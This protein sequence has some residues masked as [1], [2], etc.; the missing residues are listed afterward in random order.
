MENNFT[1]PNI[2]FNSFKDFKVRISQIPPLDV[3]FNTMALSEYE[4]LV[5]TIYRLNELI[6]YTNSYT[7]LINEI[8]IWV[9]NDGLEMAVLE[10]L[11]EWKE[12][13][14]LETIINDTLFNSK[15]DKDDFNE[16][17]SD[18]YE[19]FIDG[20]DT[21]ITDLENDLNDNLELKAD[22]TT[23]A[24][25]ADKEWT[26]TQIDSINTNLDKK[27]DIEYFENIADMFNWNL[28]LR[29]QNKTNTTDETSGQYYYSS[30]Q[31][32]CVIGDKIVIAFISAG[33]MPLQNKVVLKEYE[34][35]TGLK[36]RE[37]EV[38]DIFHA[39]GLDYN[40]ITNKIIVAYTN[41]VEGGVNNDIG[42]IS[43]SNLTLD[44]TLT[45]ENLPSGSRVKWY[46]Y[47][48]IT[49]K[50]YVGDDFA[51]H[52]IDN[53][54]KIIKTINFDTKYTD[55]RPNSTGQNGVVFNDKIYYLG[56]QQPHIAIMNMQGKIERIEPFNRTIKGN[57]GGYSTG[58][59]PQSISIDNNGNMFITVRHDYMNLYSDIYITYIFKANIFEGNVFKDIPITF[60]TY[61]Q[62]TLTVDPSTMSARPDGTS[63]KPFNNIQEAYDFATNF[64]NRRQ[65]KLY[66]KNGTYFRA[67]ILS[68]GSNVIIEGESKTGVII[69]GLIIN[70]AN[71][72]LSNLTVKPDPDPDRHAYSI[73]FKN[74]H[75]TLNNTEIDSIDQIK[76]GIICEGTLLFA[77]SSNLVKNA[78][79]AIYLNYSGLIGNIKYTTSIEGRVGAGGGGWLQN[80][81]E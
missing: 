47:D 28:G 66:L 6:T 56:L 27:L 69:N 48:K 55:A 58:K 17:V 11:L 64:G 61:T 16:F 67:N 42:V 3:A 79:R 9:V 36:V 68:N 76:D 20:I 34:I 19:V 5:A 65:I 72:H 78:N 44:I 2:D 54:F 43:Y 53:D 32:S 14:T 35:T 62:K 26:E 33:N 15:L 22:K 24:L 12:N 75:A 21:R 10:Q 39:N 46:T 59:E 37:S 1:K 4:L 40:P 23:V 63:S 81:E 31:G 45:P 80:V 57:V 18:V 38:L 71:V 51:V 70:N 74:C 41:K 25:K 73:S 30:P 7:E 29:V 49:G 60:P 50:Q 8:M 52:Q 77:N 13:G